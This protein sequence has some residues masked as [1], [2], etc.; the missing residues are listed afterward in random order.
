MDELRHHLHLILPE[1]HVI[2]AVPYVPACK[3]EIVNRDPMAEYRSALVELERRSREAGKPRS[4][5]AFAVGRLPNMDGY[6]GIGDLRMRHYDSG[7]P[8]STSHVASG[9]IVNMIYD[10][11]PYC[12]AVQA[13]FRMEYQSERTVPKYY[14]PTGHICNMVYSR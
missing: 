11:G 8:A 2:L 4:E 7:P 5:D 1:E 13:K 14:E 9:P 12:A 3:G 6:F 10:T